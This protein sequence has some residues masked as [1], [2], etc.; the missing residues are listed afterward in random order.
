MGGYRLQCLKSEGSHIPSRYG[1][2]Q[3]VL[4]AG[5]ERTVWELPL[6]FETM[7]DSFNK[8]YIYL[9][10]ITKE[11]IL[12]KNGRDGLSKAIAIL[13][14][15]WFIIQ[16][17]A[18]IHQSLA[19]TEL[20]LTTAALA[21]LNIAMYISWWSKPTDIQCP[22]VIMTKE[23]Q[24][25]TRRWMR[26]LP[27]SPPVDNTSNASSYIDSS[28][29]AMTQYTDLLHVSSPPLGL[30]DSSTGDAKAHYLVN[31]VK[32]KEKVNL[33]RHYRVEFTKALRGSL[34]SIVDFPARLGTGFVSLAR[35]LGKQ[36]RGI[37]AGHSHHSSTPHRT[38]ASD[39]NPSPD[40]RLHDHTS[41][42]E[43]STTSFIA[44]VR[45]TI[46][47]IWKAITHVFLALIYYPILAI[48]YS[49]QKLKAGPNIQDIEDLDKMTAF[50]LIFDEQTLRLVLDMVFFCEEVA[51][52]PFSCLA[53]F[54]GA[55]FGMIH[56]LAWNFE[57]PSHIEQVLWRTSSSIISGLCILIMALSLL[58]IIIKIV[59]EARGQD[60]T[61]HRFFKPKFTEM[62]FSTFAVWF[63]LTRFSLLVLSV[64]GLRA[65]P[66]SAFDTVQW[67]GFIPHV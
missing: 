49:G 2:L 23:L 52:A 8:G 62:V 40:V 64:M 16:I 47:L 29:R 31:I 21:S 61:R 58:Y 46:T 50:K 41:P 7:K 67:S 55:V 24:K 30:E 48:L 56:C 53:A 63:V 60:P 26:A 44:K 65:L 22:T 34:K 45:E 6:S 42:S 33:A 20:E 14:L 11:E 12:D 39:H 54:S 3:S 37:W 19:V 15:T 25:Q 36:I 4:I 35:E 9:P 28:P 17:A 38:P 57:F 32:D 59:K 27:S 13:Q 5:R 10:Q 66:A 43:T 18:R 1:L 51:S